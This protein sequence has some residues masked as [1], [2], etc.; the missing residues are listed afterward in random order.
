LVVAA[1]RLTLAQLGFVD[2]SE[3]VYF[4]AADPLLAANLSG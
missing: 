2:R 4:P 1:I 3:V